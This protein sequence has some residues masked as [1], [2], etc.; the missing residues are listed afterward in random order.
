NSV[1]LVDLSENENYNKDDKEDKK[2]QVVT[3]SLLQKKLSEDTK[4]SKNKCILKKY[5]KI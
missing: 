3:Q 1:E 2:I 4:M 5:S